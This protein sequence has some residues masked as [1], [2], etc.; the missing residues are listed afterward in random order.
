MAKIAIV[1]SPGAGKSTLA[2]KLGN[3]LKIE[4]IHLDKYFWQEG[5]QEQPREVW[6]DFQQRLVILQNWIID[7]TYLSTSEIRLEAA[8]TIIFL[9]RSPILCL[10]RVIKRHF[11]YAKQPRPDFSEVCLDRLNLKYIIKVFCVFPLRDRKHLLHKI[12][13]VDKLNSQGASKQVITLRSEGEVLDFLQEQAQMR[14]KIEQL[15]LEEQ[16][17][18]SD[19]TR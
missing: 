1:G 17:I 19:I 15:V 13:A 14:G 16:K 7:G 12:Q 9:D 10:W 8:D 6:E 5:W 4:V 18:P 3:L 11:K 2:R